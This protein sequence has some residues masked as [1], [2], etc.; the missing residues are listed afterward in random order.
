MNYLALYFLLTFNFL[1]TEEIETNY[2]ITEYTSI[3]NVPVIVKNE[4][5]NNDRCRLHLDS[6]EKVEVACIH[7]LYPRHVNLRI[8]CFHDSEILSHQ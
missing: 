7:E 6:G 8:S 3:K 2:S 1:N 4:R 5:I